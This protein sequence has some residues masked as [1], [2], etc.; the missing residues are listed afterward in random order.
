M[1]TET[2]KPNEYRC[3]IC[4]GVFVKGW[5]DEEAVAELSARLP[6]ADPAECDLAC[7]DCFNRIMAIMKASEYAH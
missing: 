1:T 2:L 5:S 7:D 3:C 6:E 4:H